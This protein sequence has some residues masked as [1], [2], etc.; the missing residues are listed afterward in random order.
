M[1]AGCIC[2]L[3]TKAK[4]H[5][6]YKRDYVC[7]VLTDDVVLKAAWTNEVVGTLKKGTVLLGLNPEDYKV[8]DPGD[9]GLHK[10]YV[11]LSADMDGKYRRVPQQLSVTNQTVKTY[12]YLVINP[13]E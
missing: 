12:N 9:S 1:V 11:S 7:I 4:P 3:W 2:L 10:V 13:R 8:T 5:N 6:W